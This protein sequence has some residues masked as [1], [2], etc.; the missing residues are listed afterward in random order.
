MFSDLDKQMLALRLDTALDYFYKK[1]ADN[2]PSNKIIL[3][4]KI[5]A[6][7]KCGPKAT[8]GGHVSWCIIVSNVIVPEAE[9][10]QG[11]F[12]YFLE[13]MIRMTKEKG[14]PVYIESVIT[15]ELMGYLKKR[16]EQFRPYH[17]PS[18]YVIEGQI[19]HFIHLHE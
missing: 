10:N 5:E 15:P 8:P 19:E 11:V 7:C 9:R 6:Y 1:Q 3:T 4:N 14:F 17:G 12:S 18:E 16:P 2:L 13:Q